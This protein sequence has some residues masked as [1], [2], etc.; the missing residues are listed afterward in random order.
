MPGEQAKHPKWLAFDIE[1]AKVLP[2]SAGDL[3]TYRPL[4]ISCA[5]TSAIDGELT[6]WHGTQS[7]NIADR[8]NQAEAQELVRYL[9]RMTSAGYTI[10]SWNGLGFDFDILAEESSMYPECRD[11]ALKHVD[12][13]FHFFCLKGFAVGL[14]S[15]AKGLGLKGKPKGIDGSVVPRMWA[16]GQRQQVLEY[17]AGDVRTTLEIARHVHERGQICWITSRGERKA[18]PMPAWLRAADACALP[19]PDVSW[20][21]KPWPRSKFVGW[22]RA[23]LEPL[24]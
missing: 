24:R 6:L 14:D 8:M 17:V 5:A 3:K 9:D 13:M 4:G 2:E 19:E 1:I 12:L 23:G 20:M 10:L 11:L 22:T 7:G 21:T 18:A 16:S 15:V